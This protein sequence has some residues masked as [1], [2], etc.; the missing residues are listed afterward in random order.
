MKRCPGCR[1]DYYDETLLYCLDDGTPLLE[2]PATADPDEPLTA[3]MQIP[4][5]PSQRGS[6]N[7]TRQM[8]ADSFSREVRSHKARWA[9]IAIVGL[10]VLSGFGYGLFKFFKPTSTTPAAKVSNIQTQRLSG[11]GHTRLPVISPDGKFLVYVKFEEGKESLWIKQ[12][13]T[14]ANVN[15]VKPGEGSAFSG[16]TFSPDGNFVYFNATMG[17]LEAPSIYR[18]PTLGGTPVKFLSEAVF[19]Q[20][21]YDGKRIAFRRPNAAERTETVIIANADGTGERIINTR[22]GKQYFNTA[23]AWSPDGTLLAVG[24]GDDDLGTVNCADVA[25]I[26]VDTGE[27]KIVGSRRWDWVDDIVWHPTGDSLLMVASE[28]AAELG[29]IWEITYPGGISRQVS[30]NLNGHTGVSIT[31][32]GTS[33]VTGER[34]ARS[35]VWVSPDLKAENAKQVMPSTGDTW[36]VAWM[37]DG[38]IAYASDQTGDPEIWIMNA[39]GSNARALTNDRLVKAVPAASVDGKYIVYASSRNGGEIIR[40]S[41]VDGAQLTLTHAAGA[42]NPQISPDGRWVIYSAFVDGLTKIH[43]V[44]IDGGEE[45]VLLDYF[46]TEPR[47]SNDGK[48]IACIMLDEKAVTWTKLAIVPAEGGPPSNIIEVPETINST[49]GPVWTPDD[50][51]ITLINAPGGNQELWLQPLDGSPGKQITNV[52]TLR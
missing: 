6:E 1:R 15:V 48:W 41:V 11:D 26:N 37:P 9:V 7:V 24:I 17:K 50:K 52:S 3:K 30:N 23:P 5:T 40:L 21:S 47:Y 44:S 20:F 28:R 25:T 31:A 43:R 18:V 16:I 2:G 34:Y 12:I 10:L 29:Q 33:I 35:A 42:D 51:G 27:L 13:V 38:R 49:R 22:R 45:K 14:G 19:V 39:D 32:D 4:A 46:A 36:G 8:D